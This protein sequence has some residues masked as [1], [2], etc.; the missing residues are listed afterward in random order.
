MSTHS[1][2]GGSS[3][4]LGLAVAALV[5]GAALVLL[6]GQ[7]TAAAATTTKPGSTAPVRWWV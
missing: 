3:R 2:A 4:L 7:A 1:I 5:V 6:A